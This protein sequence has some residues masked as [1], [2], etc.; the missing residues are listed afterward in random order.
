MKKSPK[1]YTPEVPEKRV[2][3]TNPPY[4][5]PTSKPS[6]EVLVKNFTYKDF[7]KILDKAP[8]TI[9]EW[10][11]MLFISERTLHRYA[12]DNSSF[13]GLQIERILL[14]EQLIDTGNEL[15]GKEGF[16]TW[17]QSAP[18][19]LDSDRVKDK[20]TTHN[21]IQDVIDLLGRIQ[22]GIPA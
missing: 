12:K 1:K 15:F 11:D 7:K 21:G 19:S 4:P 22:H 3:H 16:K 14:L 5:T 20:L 8:F 13:N 6:L 9:G 2:A 18:F 17:L 10:A